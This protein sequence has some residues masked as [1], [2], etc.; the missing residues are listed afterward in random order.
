M[1]GGSSIHKKMGNDCD[2]H[3]PHFL[4]IFDVRNEFYI[5]IYVLNTCIMCMRC[6]QSL[7]I[8]KL[9][10]ILQIKSLKKLTSDSNST[11]LEGDVIYEIYLSCYFQ[12][13]W[14]G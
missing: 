1:L 10:I 12:A 5:F 6:S 7:G 8:L 4:W 14:N 2:I 13:Y 3:V 9:M 11:Y